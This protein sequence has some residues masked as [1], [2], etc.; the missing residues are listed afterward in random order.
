[1]CLHDCRS[2]LKQLLLSNECSAGWTH[3][4]FSVVTTQP[5]S[6]D[7]P[8]PDDKTTYIP[9]RPPA[10]VY[11]CRVNAAKVVQGRAVVTCRFVLLPLS[12]TFQAG[13]V[14]TVVFAII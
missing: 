6:W 9:G 8:I 5:G 4:E 11:P 12:G 2:T 14:H 13:E 7:C 3:W 1:M 10:Y